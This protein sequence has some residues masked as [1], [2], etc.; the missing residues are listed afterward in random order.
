VICNRLTLLCTLVLPTLVLAQEK[1]TIKL[2]HSTQGEVTMNTREETKK[3]AITVTGADGNVL[4]EK[5]QTSI[6]I[7]KYKEEIIEKTAGQRTT[8]AKRSYSESTRKTDDAMEQR[9]Y[10]GKVVD[11]ERKGDDYLFTVDGKEL[12]AAEA[13]DLANSFNAK[14]PTDEEVDKLLLPSKPVA[15]GDSWDIDAKLFVKQLGGDEKL[16]KSFD[17]EKAKASGKLTKAYK[18]DG[19]QHGVVEFTISI[20]MKALEGEHPCRD[21]SKMDLTM[22][23]DGCIDGTVQPES[24]TMTMKVAGTA[25]FVQD[26]QK[27]GVTIK[28]DV[29]GVDKRKATTVKK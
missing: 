23:V 19:R 22:V 3:E 28:F 17:A 21:G 5:T 4:Q 16:A 11:I 27:T 14:K 6:D 26:G 13:G 25:D 2:K 29:N 15:V 7:N 20:P 8:K 1:Y 10:H 9:S 12:P 24:A 18:T